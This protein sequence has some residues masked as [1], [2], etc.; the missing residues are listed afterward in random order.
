M[1]IK[2]VALLVFGA[3]LVSAQQPNETITC[4]DYFDGRFLTSCDDDGACPIDNSVCDSHQ[5]CVCDDDYVPCKDAQYSNYYDDYRYGGGYGYGGQQA[6]YYVECIRYNQYGVCMEYREY[7]KAEDIKEDKLKGIYCLKKA[8]LDEKCYASN[9]CR[10]SLTCIRFDDDTVGTCGCY[11]DFQLTVDGQCIS[12]ASIGQECN[13]NLNCKTVGAE[14]VALPMDF[15]SNNGYY[16]SRN[17]ENRGPMI[18]QCPVEKP[19]YY[20]PEDLCLEEGEQDG[21]CMLSAQCQAALGPNSICHPDTQTCVCERGFH[22]PRDGGE[23]CV[24]APRKEHHQVRD[25][26]Q[27]QQQER[28]AFVENYINKKR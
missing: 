4:D 27:Q 24:P 17:V 13:S 3:V 15:N 11:D 6:Q 14:C 26:E 8:D 1:L 7:G 2:A 10:G 12:K 9:Q 5:R 19:F 18:C 23:E 25:S 28:G 20:E 22:V 16:Y 21:V